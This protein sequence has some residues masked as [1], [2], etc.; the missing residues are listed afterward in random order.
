MSKKKE[1]QRHSYLI[2]KPN[3]APPMVPKAARTYMFE[4]RYMVAVIL[5]SWPRVSGESIPH[6]C[7]HVFAAGEYPEKQ[8]LIRTSADG[9]DHHGE[10]HGESDVEL[11]CQSAISGPEN[12]LG[13]TRRGL[14]TR[15]I[16]NLTDIL[17]CRPSV[18][19]ASMNATKT[20][21]HMFQQ[22]SHPHPSS[23]F[24]RALAS[25]CAPLTCIY[26]C[27]LLG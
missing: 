27:A 14:K 26:I 6:I 22:A 9:S 20:I 13:W 17:A 25:L 2:S 11:N 7:L 15:L 8:W 4:M 23:R 12:C 18:A 19:R 10:P 21:R 16:S 24:I 1:T 5:V 3:K